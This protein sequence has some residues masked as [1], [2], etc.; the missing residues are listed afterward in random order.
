MGTYEVLFIISPK[1]GDDQVTSTIEEFKGIAT[2][3]GLTIQSEDFW[4]RRRL[5]YPIKKVQDGFYHLM[6]LEG[7][8]AGLGELDRKMKNSDS[9]M[10]HMI[11]RTDLEMMRAK[12]LAIKNPLKPRVRPAPDGTRGAA[13]APAR[14]SAPAKAAAPET[15]VKP[16]TAATPVTAATPETAAEASTTEN[17]QQGTAP[18]ESPSES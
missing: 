14:A 13:S 8:G 18:A 5:A 7:D 11:V 12:K 16:E 6:I 9:I 1:L 3:G 10:R 2:E 17:A 15:A 4:G